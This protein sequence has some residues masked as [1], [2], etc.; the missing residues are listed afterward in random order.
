MLDPHHSRLMAA[1]SAIR[2][3]NQDLPPPEFAWIRSGVS[4]SGGSSTS[5]FFALSVVPM[6]MGHQ[7][8]E[9]SELYSLAFI[10][11]SL[12]HLSD[13]LLGGSFRIFALP[14]MATFV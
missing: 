5:N 3:S 7:K 13:R 8:Y 1:R 11:P 2:R 6:I 9:S 10:L 14:L 12:P 4:T